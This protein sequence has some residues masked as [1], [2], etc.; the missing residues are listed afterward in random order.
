MPKGYSTWQKKQLVVKASE[1]MLITGQLYKLGP[2]EILCRCIINHE[3]QW[4]VAEVHGG[5]LRGHYVGKATVRK[6]L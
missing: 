6:I 2:D 4:V 3:I 5:F 1:Y